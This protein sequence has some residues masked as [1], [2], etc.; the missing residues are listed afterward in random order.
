LASLAFRDTFQAGIS[1]FGLSEL[2]IFLKDTHKFE[3]RYL[4][5]LIGPYPKEKALY[6]ERSPIHRADHITCPLLLLQGAEDPIVP[7]NQS[8]LM[9]KSLIQRGIPTAYLV[10]EG[11]QHGFRQAKNIRRSL[12]AQE[13][14]L[15]QVFGYSLADPVEPIE[16]VG[17]I[18]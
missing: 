3:S 2:E 7:P 9:Y 14:F 17:S 15:S 13:Y 5:G 18:L 4:D 11:E 16:I 12:E 8:E 6:Q 1:L 10:F